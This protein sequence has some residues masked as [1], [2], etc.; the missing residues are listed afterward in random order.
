[1]E[2]F[3]AYSFTKTKT[4]QIYNPITSLQGLVLKQVKSHNRGRGIFICD[5]CLNYFG[6]QELLD[7]HEEICSQHK[8]V[9]T[10]YPEPGKN[11]ILKF[12]NIENCIECPI[13]FYVDTESILKPIDE[14]KGKTKLFQ[15]HKMSTFYLYPVLRIGDNSVTI[16]PTEAIGTDD[17]DNIAKILVKKLEEK[18]KEVYEKFREPVKM[19]F[20]GTAR[21]SFESAEKCYACGE[22][23]N[24]DKVCDHDHFTG[25]YR[26]A[27]HSECN[28]KL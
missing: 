8:A 12:K 4:E 11:D 27:L 23:L 15:R 18:A 26:G 25:R 5:Y 3:T 24:G 28:L 13:K 1:M 20:D 10:V 17:N 6:T 19:V 9:K 22:E 7:D 16:E 21:I 14:T 2:R